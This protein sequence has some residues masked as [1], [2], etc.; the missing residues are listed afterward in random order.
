MR[1]KTTKCLFLVGMNNNKQ[2]FIRSN[3]GNANGIVRD[4]GIC[5][6]VNSIK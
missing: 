4:K 1:N 6:H 2:H 5:E 3:L